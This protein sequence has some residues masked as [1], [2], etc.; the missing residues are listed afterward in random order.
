MRMPAGLDSQSI[1]V[2]RAQ[3][4]VGALES[5]TIEQFQNIRQLQ[6]S[7]DATF[8]FGSRALRPASGLEGD[9]F[10]AT[11]LNTLYFYTGLAWEVAVG[12][13]S[14]T[15]ATR[16]AITPDA[17]DNGLFFY[18]TDTG[19]LWE[20]S[21]GAWVDRFVDI[22]VTT[23]YKVG[24]N[25]VVKARGAAVAD[26]ASADAS[27]L[28]TAITLVNELKTQVNLAFARLRSTTGHGLWT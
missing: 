6:G 15:D 21:G 11:D 28:A 24:S 22:A 10:L 1:D 12:F 8:T 20:V 9:R 16:A 18:A 26:V 4:Q 17:T 13:I 3:R 7:A 27:D 19:K 25:Y 2:T 14:G 23:G 5:E